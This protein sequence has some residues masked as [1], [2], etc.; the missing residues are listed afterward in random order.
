M[1]RCDLSLVVLLSLAVGLSFGCRSDT[2]ESGA[3]ISGEELE[4][5]RSKFIA[6]DEPDGAIGVLDL[7]DQLTPAEAVEGE[8][9]P[10]PPPESVEVVVVG[11]ICAKTS[12]ADNPDFP[13]QKG[14]ATFMMIDPGF[15]PGEHAHEHADG[16]ECPFCQKNEQDAQALVRFCDQQGE[17]VPVDARDLLQAEEEQ[18]VVVKGTATVLA[19]ML[20]I[21][22]ESIHV[23]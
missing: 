21:E 11:K 4:I 20:M 16:E 17:V 22:A 15:V 12:T 18:L 14:R 6:I 5:L 1:K 7:R 10:E 8:A 2:T 13:W 19:G 9:E 3:Q 23:R